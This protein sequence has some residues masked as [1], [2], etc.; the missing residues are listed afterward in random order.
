M[1]LFNVPELLQIKT[2]LV[3][4]MS[5]LEESPLEPS[6]MVCGTAAVR[7]QLEALV[8]NIGGATASCYMLLS[9]TGVLLGASPG[10]AAH[11]T[12]GVQRLHQMCH[13]LEQHRPL[14]TLGDMVLEYAQVKKPFDESRKTSERYR[15][16]M[17]ESTRSETSEYASSM[18][19]LTTD[20]TFLYIVVGSCL[21]KVG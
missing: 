9:L 2:A 10:R 15:K 21:L 5:A 3:N 6:S 17:R 4:W 11:L 16:R 20:G 14:V 13:A 19:A 12:D 1:S 18:E 7:E 8:L